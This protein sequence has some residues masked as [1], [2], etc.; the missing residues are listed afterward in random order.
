MKLRN[1][2]ALK[3]TAKWLDAH[4]NTAER[5]AVSSTSHAAER[6]SNEY[7]VAAVCSF[8]CADIYGLEVIKKDIEDI[9]SKW[10]L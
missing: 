10:N 7:G 1:V 5:V 9:K 4:L 2:K 6:A 8:A 3:Q